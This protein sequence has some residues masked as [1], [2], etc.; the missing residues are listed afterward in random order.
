MK[1]FQDLGL[2]QNILLALQQMGFEKPTPIQEKTIPLLLTDDGDLI[3]LAQ[4][5]TGK[6][7]AF[8]LPALEKINPENKKPQVLVLAPTRELA[9]QITGDFNSFAS[10]LKGIRSVTVYGGANI[11]QQ[12]SGIQKGAQ[13]IVATPGRAVDLIKRRALNLNHIHTLVLDEADEML[14]MGFKEDLD[15]ILGQTPED[16]QSLLFSATMSKEVERMARKYLLQP[17][18]ISVSNPN[19]GADT[20]RHQAYLTTSGKRYQTLKRLTDMHPEMYGIIF[21]RTRRDTKTIASKLSQDGYNADALHGDLSQNQRDD[22]MRKFRKKQIQLLVATDVAARGIDIHNLTHII[23]YHLPDQTEYYT[24][25]S[26]RTGRAGNDG[27]SMALIT[28]RDKR[29]LKE[30]ER[31]SH[32]KFQSHDVPGAKEILTT[33]IMNFAGKVK[34][35]DTSHKISD[36]LMNQL[37]ETFKG[38]SREEI[39]IH[40]IA[41]KFQRILQD[42]NKEQKTDFK[43]KYNQRKSSEDDNMQRLFLNIGKRDKLTPLKLI[44]IINN[45]LDSGDAE[46]GKIEILNNFSFFQ[47]EKQLADDLIKQINGNYHNNRQMVVDKANARPSYAGKRKSKRMYA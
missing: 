12:I 28:T 2:S 5:G 14:N 40:F 42:E 31:I 4:T 15:F 17:K 39:I 47:I 3:A 27:I 19:K 43:E 24:H 20:I 23:H 37:N 44:G 9:L 13:I 21:C 11:N 25:R 30:I 7:A 22:V 26:G 46:I 34:N 33:Q 45:A 29:K 38:L 36:S 32:I 35:T 18:K 16:K 41:E 10:F 6:T 8:A 1:T